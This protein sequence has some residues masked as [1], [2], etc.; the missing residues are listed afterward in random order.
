MFMD[1]AVSPFTQGLDKN[2]AN[3]AALSP[4][5]FLA[6]AADVFPET[7]AIVHG[8]QRTDYRTFYGRARRL[9]SALRCCP[10]CR[11]CSR[12]IYGV[13]MAGAVLHSI[14]TRLDA[15][16]IAFQ[17][18]HARLQGADHRPGVCA[19]RQGSALSGRKRIADGDR[20]FRPG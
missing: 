4:L 16:I 19:R 10:T 20:L 12:P 6:R 9:A 5:S 11:R 8:S 7:T 13:P 18:D 14:N 17:L 1:A 15:D 2:R 3:Y